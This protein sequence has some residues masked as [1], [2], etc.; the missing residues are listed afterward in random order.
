MRDLRLRE[1][2][3]ILNTFFQKA[4]L[5]AQLTG[6][7]FDKIV[8][9][10]AL[11]HWGMFNEGDVRDNALNAVRAVLMMRACLGD[12]NEKRIAAGLS[13][14]LFSF[15]MNTG[16]ASLS[17]FC[18]G[19]ISEYSVTGQAVDG[20]YH[21]M[22]QTK[23]A[24][25]EI[26]MTTAMYDLIAKF[27]IA[28]EITP[29]AGEKSREADTRFFT[30]INIREKAATTRLLKDLARIADIDMAVAATFA[31]PRG[32]KTLPELRA[33]LHIPEV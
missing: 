5:C 16:T 21:G 20:A 29:S 27:I 10:K 25:T 8:G 9:D 4:G 14:V 11:F 17:S 6:G 30:L 26:N 2:Q 32:P 19:G 12:W 3:D 15:G 23:A 28:D 18:I 24:K 7:C 13:P 33:I 31:G 1:K 22:L